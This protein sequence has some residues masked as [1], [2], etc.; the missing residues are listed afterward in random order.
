MSKVYIG[1]GHGGS[2]SG[3]VAN[4]FKEKDLNLSVGSACAAYLRKAGVEVRQSRTDD[5]DVYINTKVREANDWGADLVL[6]IHHNAGG[7]D[8]IEVY[9]YR[10]GGT[11]KTLAE[12]II[13]EVVKIGQNS[14]GAKV[15]LGSSGRDYFGIIRDTYAPAVLVECAFMDSSDIKIVDTEAERVRMGEAIARGILKTL[16]VAIPSEVKGDI[17]G[18]GKV[19][20]KDYAEAL[21]IAAKTKT[22]TA[23]QIERGDMD[24]DGDIDS[25][26]AR[27]IGRKAAKLE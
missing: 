2:D 23:E 10:G 17:N 21:K 9:H 16:G 22:P 3:A 12:N 7:G 14:R 6:D 13:A 24:G 25:R 8:G 4:G 15:R 19:T 11:S 1:I 20:S 26:D 27:T 18:D 5:R